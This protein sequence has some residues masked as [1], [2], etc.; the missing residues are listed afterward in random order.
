VKARFDGQTITG[1]K[2]S[3]T[4]DRWPSTIE[5]KSFPFRLSFPAEKSQHLPEHWNKHPQLSTFFHVG[6]IANPKRHPPS[7]IEDNRLN[8]PRDFNIVGFD[9]P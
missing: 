9:P 4:A 6:N 7:G 3:A 8:I 2:G 1:A 5:S